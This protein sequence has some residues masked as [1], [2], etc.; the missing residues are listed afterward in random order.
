MKLGD[1]TLGKAPKGAEVAKFGIR[2]EHMAVTTKAKA[3][4]SGTV[5]HTEHLG[6]YALGYLTLDN[7]VEFTAKLEDSDA[8]ATGDVIHLTYDDARTHIFDKNGVVIR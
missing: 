6:E 1:A 2:P 7:G 4:L 8:L 3:K 5:R